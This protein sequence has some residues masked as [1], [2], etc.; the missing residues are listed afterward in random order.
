MNAPFLHAQMQGRDQQARTP[1]HVMRLVRALFFEAPRGGPVYD[2]CPANRAAGFDGLATPWRRR[3]YVNPPYNAVAVWMR[4]ASEE[5]QRH[6]R[7]SVLLVPARTYTRYFADVAFPRASHLLFLLHRVAF[8]GYRAPLPEPLMLAAFGPLRPLPPS[9][10][11]RQA[12]AIEWRPARLID[13]TAAAAATP[14]TQRR[15]RKGRADSCS[16][17]ALGRVLREHYGA[18]DRELYPA[19]APLRPLRSS[20]QRPRQQLLIVGDQDVKTHAAAVAA[21]HGEPAHAHVRTVLVLRAATHTRYFAERLLP[22][23]LE[24]GFVVPYLHGVTGAF[25]ATAAAEP[26]EGPEKK[27]RDAASTSGS[28]VLLLASHAAAAA[29]AAAAPPRS[30]PH[31]LRPSPRPAA[32]SPQSRTVGFVRLL[33]DSAGLTANHLL[34]DE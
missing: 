8:A 18:F 19:T 7:S 29:A 13:L 4:K 30:P 10:R 24:V 21:F 17:E 11:S 12:Y 22:L 5:A 15:R 25:T 14:P 1:A 28:M 6:Q 32:A 26:G 16:P 31:P 23:V 33:K 27:R 2:P 3:N 20:S 34:R 9:P